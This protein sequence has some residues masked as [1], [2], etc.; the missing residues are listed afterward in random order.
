MH[1]HA[2]VFSCKALHSVTLSAG[3]K[4]IS[5][6]CFEGCTAF[7]SVTLPESLE[8]IQYAAFYGCSSL[9]SV[10]MPPNVTIDVRAF[11]ACGRLDPATRDRI[12]ELQI[13]DPFRP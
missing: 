11:Y 7:K 8:R 4:T 9:V 5:R 13:C 1:L 3:V 12:A 6:S 2:A 10:V